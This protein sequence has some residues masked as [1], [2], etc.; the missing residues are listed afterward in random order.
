MNESPAAARIAVPMPRVAAM[1]IGATTFGRMCRTRITRIGTPMTRAASTYNCSLAISTVLRTS[2][3]YTGIPAMP[4]AI[5]RLRR[6]GPSTLTMPSAS[7]M[8]GNASRTSIRRMIR[9][10]TPPP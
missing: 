10:S 1:M 9:P 3:A 6:L 2:R 4:T 8:P 5:I 7:R